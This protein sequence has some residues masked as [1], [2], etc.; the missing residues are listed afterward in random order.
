MVIMK[1]LSRGMEYMS[2]IVIH[3]PII[4]QYGSSCILGIMVV[5]VFL[6]NNITQNPASHF[7]YNS[8]AALVSPKCLQI[9]P[10]PFQN[11]MKF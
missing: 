4:V 8:L 7:L 6:P 5:S 9:N 11:I 1:R 10:K 2:S 3:Q